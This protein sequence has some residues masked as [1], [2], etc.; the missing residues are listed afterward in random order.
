MR[1]EIQLKALRKWMIDLGMTQR[2][3][4]KECGV[5]Q[6]LV[7]LVIYGKRKN[8]KVIDFLLSKGCP[9]SLLN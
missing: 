9:R 5:T 8:Q 6:S 4:G 2:Q 1:T 7:S 3:I